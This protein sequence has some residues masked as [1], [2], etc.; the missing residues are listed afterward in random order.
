MWKEA[1]ASHIK[2]VSLK[3][4]EESE[5]GELVNWDLYVGLHLKFC[6]KGGYVLLSPATSYI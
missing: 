5:D 3:P 1:I 2:K 4:P 6:M